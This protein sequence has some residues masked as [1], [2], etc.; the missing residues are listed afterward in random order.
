MIDHGFGADASVELV[1]EM[2]VTAKEHTTELGKIEGF[3]EK[4]ANEFEAEF[5]T[6]LM[7][8]L[9]LQFPKKFME[10]RTLLAVLVSKTS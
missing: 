5:D 3:E 9:Y 6:K 4:E 8:P 10:F 7:N 2:I 1:E